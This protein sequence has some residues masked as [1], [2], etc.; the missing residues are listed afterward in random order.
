[1]VLNLKKHAFLIFKAGV[2][3]VDPKVLLKQMVKLNNNILTVHDR[4]YD[5]G[6][7]EKIIIVGGGKA[8]V[9]MASAI[10]EILQG[11]I[12][13]G[14][15]ITSYGRSTT[16]QQV[17]IVE[18]GHPIPDENGLKGTSELLG[19]LNSSGDNTLVICLISGGASAL[20]TAP[21]DTISIKHVQALTNELLASGATIQ[22]INTVRKHLSRIKGGNLAATAKPAT[23]VTLILSDVVGNPLDVIASGPTVPDPTTYSNSVEVLDK[24]GLLIK[25]PSPVIEHLKRGEMGEIPE[26]PK[27]GDPLFSKVQ[28]CIIGTNHEALKAAM[29]RAE[30]LG[31][32]TVILS[33]SIEGEARD[34]AKIHVN[35]AK[36]I[37]E[38]NNPIP[39]PACLLFGGETTVTVLGTGK[40]G[41][42]QEYVLSFAI[43]LE[44]AKSISV[45]SAGT[46]GID[47]PT[48]AAGAFANGGTSHKAEAVGLDPIYHLNNNDS[49]SL[50][51]AIDDLII[52][53]PT[54]TNVMD[55]SIILVV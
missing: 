24:Y 35:I 32:N 6:Q 19:I 36:E 46:D 49:Y 17:R 41:R 50:F 43:E 14:L 26:T 18:A 30:K 10:E 53:G 28:N 20:L 37:L 9:A 21:Y 22:E 45:L 23:V 25:S 12:S 55:L 33:S 52:T 11:K 7:F 47:G 34:V 48:D 54:N 2:E 5:L 29:K 8:S 15:V 3:A 44:S 39:K 27:P 51:K 42:N 31:F 16:T 4:E 38:N 13:D 1:M 40:G